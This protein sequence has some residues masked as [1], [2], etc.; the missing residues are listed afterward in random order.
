MFLRRTY[1]FFSQE[2]VQN[3]EK[4][5]NRHEK[6]SG[7]KSRVFQTQDT[8][9]IMV[10]R[11]NNTLICLPI[12]QFA[13]ASIRQADQ[14][15]RLALRQRVSILEQQLVLRSATGEREERTYLLMVMKFITGRS[16]QSLK[17]HISI[18]VSDTDSHSHSNCDC[19][20]TQLLKGM[21]QLEN[22][23]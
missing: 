11:H 9:I 18:K 5:K 2:T 15:Q 22:L 8:I 21:V 16:L 17:V 10:K 7:Y 3:R 23:C 20:W 19:P 6:Y 12:P 13:K 14:L 1:T 4:S